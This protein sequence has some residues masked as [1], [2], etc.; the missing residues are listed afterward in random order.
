MKPFNKARSI[1]EYFDVPSLAEEYLNVYIFGVLVHDNKDSVS[2]TPED[3]IGYSLT[4]TIVNSFNEEV[5]EGGIGIQRVEK[6]ISDHRDETDSFIKN[7]GQLFPPKPIV[8]ESRNHIGYYKDKLQE[9]FSF[10]LFV[11]M[12]LFSK[13]VDLK[14]FYTEEGQN[15]GENE[16][17]VEIKNDTLIKVTGNI[18]IEYMEKSAAD[19]AIFVES[20]ILKDDNT[21]F[22]FIGE[23]D[24]YW[25]LRKSDLRKIFDE[26]FALHNAHQPS[27]RGVGFR[28]IPTSRGMLLPKEE[29]N[30]IKLSLNELIDELK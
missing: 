26:E 28:T 15:S 18:Y 10:E 19:N 1:A 12:L 5:K 27:K 21:R 7:F 4:D 30:K 13:G 6:Y 20:G 23:R 9:S 24:A 17:G 14:P 8:W 3:Y 11:Y 29:A 2:F 16:L 22:L 25:I